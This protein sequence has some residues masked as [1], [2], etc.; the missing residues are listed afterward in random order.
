MIPAKTLMDLFDDAAR[1]AR[2]SGDYHGAAVFSTCESAV[3]NVHHGL[4]VAEWLP[5]VHLTLDTL[6]D[7]AT[8]PAEETAI[9]DATEL[10]AMFA[11]DMKVNR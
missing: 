4:A 10:L 7:L 11:E 9:E 3:N 2:A 5:K 6:R 1:D 8:D